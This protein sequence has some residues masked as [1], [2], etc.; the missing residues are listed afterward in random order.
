MIRRKPL[1]SKT[2]LANK[3]PIQ[4]RTPIR[5]I[6]SNGGKHIVTQFNTLPAERQSRAKAGG[7]PAHIRVE[8]ER[9]S[10]GL[11]Q[12]M[13]RGCTVVASHVH[14]RQMRSQGGK[15]TLDNLVHLCQHCHHNMIH[16]RPAWAYEHG[17]LVRR[18][19]D[20]AAI[21]ISS[22]GE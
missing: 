2:P 6:R 13:L 9:R 7:V 11:C 5:R 3:T 15:H 20:P 14:H 1:V 17:W 10:H 16:G 22:T 19:D 12:A 18:G 21:A 8:V 4:R